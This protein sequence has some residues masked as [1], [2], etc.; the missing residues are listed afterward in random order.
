MSLLELLRQPRDPAQL[1]H[2]LGKLRRLSREVVKVIAERMLL[3]VDGLELFPIR[4]DF[5]ILNG[6]DDDD[7]E[8][9]PGKGDFIWLHFNLTDAGAE[10]WIAQNLAVLKAAGLVLLAASIASA[11]TLTAS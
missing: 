3:A 11:M 10:P 9:S 7:G 5:L 4:T 1:A 2:D 6:R 8:S